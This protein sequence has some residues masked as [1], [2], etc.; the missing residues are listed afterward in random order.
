MRAKT[1]GGYSLVEMVVAA[2]ILGL[3]MSSL[4]SMQ[5]VANR[6]IR[7]TALHSAADT[8]LQR[9]IFE[10]SALLVNSAESRISLT[11]SGGKLQRI[12]LSVSG[13]G[14]TWGAYDDV[15]EFR[16]GWH[17]E[18]TLDAEGTLWLET[19]NNLM[20]LE[21][22]RPL[23]RKLTAWDAGKTATGISLEFRA[24]VRQ[25]DALPEA[26]RTANTWIT[27]RQKGS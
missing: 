17:H 27:F 13:S 8:R 9:A 18:L 5:M 26:E 24:S 15:G 23:A 10:V 7:Q 21:T 25:G 14:G 22:N 1:S 3:L 16:S 11:T 4:F 12:N 6:C 19:Y 20:A 2:S